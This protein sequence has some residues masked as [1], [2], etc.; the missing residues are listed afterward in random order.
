MNPFEWRVEHLPEIDSTNTWLKARALEGAPE[1][2]AVYADFQS[3]GRGRLDRQWE[4]TAG[5]ALLCS[6]LVRPALDLD[7]L[8]LVVAGVALSA[9]A[10]LGQLCGVR[11]DLKWPNDLLVDDAKLAGL[12]AEVVATDQGI[13]VVVGLGLNLTGHPSHAHATDVLASSGVVL[14]PGVLLQT[15]LADFSLRYTQL[16]HAD[17]RSEVTRN[18]S[19]SL[20]TLGRRVRV[21]T[22]DGQFV[23]VALRVDSLS[24]LVV[25]VQGVEMTFSVGDVVHVRID[26]EVVQ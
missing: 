23:G 3:A 2:L 15:L 7:Q 25:D 26:S 14:D 24:R 22:R 17:G 16:E 6:L 1:G 4:S 9:Q 5:A 10:A 12:L 20:A 8:Q 21:S 11:P 13:A 18:Y 19:S